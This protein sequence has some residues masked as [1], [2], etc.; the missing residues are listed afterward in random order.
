[1][2]D[3]ETGKALGDINKKVNQLEETMDKILNDFQKSCKASDMEL[4]TCMNCIMRL[5][6]THTNLINEIEQNSS[7]S[8]DMKIV[9]RYYARR[10]IYG[11]ITLEVVPDMFRQKVKEYLE[12]VTNE[13]N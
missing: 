1:M 8:E 11:D 12:E 4:F 9:V 13:E 6:S 10:V 5:F 7:E 2:I 3:P